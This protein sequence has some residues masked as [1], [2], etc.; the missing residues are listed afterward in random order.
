[1][2]VTE[3]IDVIGPVRAGIGLLSVLAGGFWLVMSPFG[4]DLTDAFMGAVVAA[5]GLVLLLWHRLGLSGR[6]V[7]V[8]AG[9]TGVTGALAGLTVYA[10]GLCCM[11]SFF[12]SRGWPLTWL[13]RGAVADTSDEAIRL[14]RAESWG[15]YPSDLVIDLVV[16]AYAGMVLAVL[17]GLVVR[18]IRSR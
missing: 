17:I 9:V 6:L 11:F 15:V 10:S 16:W 3:K 4:G 13:G 14:A 1:M 12:E 5:G 18:A 8:A 2:T 7:S